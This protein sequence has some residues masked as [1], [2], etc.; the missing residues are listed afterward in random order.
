MQN[1]CPRKEQRLACSHRQTKYSCV[2]ALKSGWCMRASG[3]SRCGMASRRDCRITRC[4]DRTSHHS[5]QIFRGR[6]GRLMENR[7]TWWPSDRK[8]RGGIIITRDDRGG[9]VVAHHEALSC[10]CQPG[11]LHRS[12]QFFILTPTATTV[13]G[14]DKTD[15]QLAGTH[16]AIA[17]R[18]VVVR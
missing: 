9:D 2:R 3:R 18:I 6:E 12:R 11:E 1:R 4:Y 7:A 17:M 14:G 10:G 5:Q 13:D 8:D 15:L 16:R